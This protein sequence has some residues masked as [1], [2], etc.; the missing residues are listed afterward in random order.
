MHTWSRKDTFD[1][2]SAH[3][4]EGEHYNYVRKFRT[5]LMFKFQQVRVRKATK[6]DESGM[7]LRSGTS[8]DLLVDES[9]YR[10]RTTKVKRLSRVHW[11]DVIQ[12]KEGT[13]VVLYIAHESDLVRKKVATVQRKMVR[14]EERNMS[15][16]QRADRGDNKAGETI[17]LSGRKYIC[18]RAR[19]QTARMHHDAMNG[20]ISLAQLQTLYDRNEGFTLRFDGVDDTLTLAWKE[21]VELADQVLIFGRPYESTRNYDRLFRDKHKEV[22]V[23]QIFQDL[24]RE[25]WGDHVASYALLCAYQNRLLTLAREKKAEPKIQWLN[26]YETDKTDAFFS[27]L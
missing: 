16:Q 27:G 17:S 15:P 9:A 20:L 10:M 21:M 5:N 12:L 11:E 7:G 22:Y 26:F 25:T 19:I 3:V 14:D 2:A 18:L 24:S 4:D 1:P 8:P 13:P 23:Q 6:A